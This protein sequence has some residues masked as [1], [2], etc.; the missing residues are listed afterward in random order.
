[1]TASQSIRNIFNILKRTY[2]GWKEDR[3][4]RLAASLAYYTTFS[5]APLLVI[6]IA[7]AGFIWQRQA[8]EAQVLAQ[9]QSLAGKEGTKFVSDLIESARDPAEGIIAATFGLV[10]LI[11]GAVGVFNEL[12]NALNTIWEVEVEKTEGLLT[13]VKKIILDRFLSFTMVLGIG[14]L[15]LVSLIVSAALSAVHEFLGNVVLFP[16]VLLQAINLVLSIGVITLLFALIF[17]Y[18]PDA[19][20]AWRDVWVGAVA[21][22][23]LFSLGKLGIGLYLGNSAVTSS[24]GAAGSL[25]LIL[26][27]AYYSAQI[28][29]FGAEFTQVYANTYGS[30][31]RPKDTVPSATAGSS[32]IKDTR[33]DRG[34]AQKPT[35]LTVPTAAYACKGNKNRERR[36][37]SGAC[38][39]RSDG[40]CVYGWNS[41]DLGVKTK[42]GDISSCADAG[43]SDTLNII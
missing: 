1:V 20:I 7:V 32:D 30:R 6:A 2:Q 36:A 16:E 39:F 37:R 25:V 11:F 18:L 19:E 15:L 3:A 14:F 33:G 13:S 12:H 23:I 4:S 41:N 10:S 34:E 35:A 31:I 29:F 28:L 26:V 42:V 27:W 22:A 21:T 40:G 9:V 8:V 38:R 5:L 17:K 24:F 43:W